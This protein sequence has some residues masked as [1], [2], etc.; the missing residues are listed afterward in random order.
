VKLQETTVTKKNCIKPVAAVVGAALVGSLSAVNV[1][2][3]AEN[4]FGASQL[5]RGYMVLA[6]SHESAGKEGEGKCGEGKCGG[7]KKEGEG[8][9]G[10]DKKEGEGK[11]GEGKCGEGKCGGDKKKES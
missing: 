4:P 10:G 1:V 7:D 2:S 11:C 3:A 6:S 8:K 5:D 9:C